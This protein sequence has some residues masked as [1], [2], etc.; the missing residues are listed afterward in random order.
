MDPYPTRGERKAQGVEAVLQ[1]YE[2][3][4]AKSQRLPDEVKIGREFL[5]G[6][7]S[8]E[9]HHFAW[10]RGTGA[11]L[12]AE[13]FG[14][15]ELDYAGAIAERVQSVLSGARLVV[16]NNHDLAVRV[17]IGGARRS[18]KTQMLHVFRNE[19]LDE[20][21]T[22]G[23]WKQ[24]FFFIYP[25]KDLFSV[26]SVEDLPLRMLTAV[27]PFLAWQRPLLGEYLGAIEANFASL[28]PEPGNR[29]YMGEYPRSAP[30]F[31]RKQRLYEKLPEFTVALERVL[32]DLF[33]VS[34]EPD[35]GPF[36]A[37]CFRLPVALAAA[38]GCSRFLLF[39]DDFELSHFQPAGGTLEQYITG[40][41][42]AFVGVSWVLTKS[43]SATS[44]HASRVCGGR[45]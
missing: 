19:L 32:Q 6:A 41:K 35:K 42:A 10:W 36:I 38:A 39:A 12:A 34:R 14:T 3:D 30:T 33:V 9:G 7:M 44:T 11:R 31:S 8:H 4:I 15:V 18:G 29:V 43:G 13:R 2:D 45:S 17:A 26:E 20:V 40:V 24:S 16:G 21:A 23:T 1:V 22:A 27:W 25:L 37:E 5:A 28:I